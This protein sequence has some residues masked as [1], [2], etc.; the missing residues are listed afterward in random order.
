MNMKKIVNLRFAFYVVMRVFV[1]VALISISFIVDI[2][3]AFAVAG[4][5]TYDDADSNWTY[6][7]SWAA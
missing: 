5:G 4:A 3:P 6:T 7:G 1:L 2:T